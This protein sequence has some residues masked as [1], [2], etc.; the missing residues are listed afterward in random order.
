ME[1]KL[2]IKN[3]ENYYHA[4]LILPFKSFNYLYVN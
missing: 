1:I 4:N 2:V 3:L